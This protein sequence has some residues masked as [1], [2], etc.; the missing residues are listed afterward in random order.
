MID[1]YPSTE[2]RRQCRRRRRRFCCASVRASWSSCQVMDQPEKVCTHSDSRRCRRPT[3]SDFQWLQQFHDVTGIKSMPTTAH[4]S[5][6][7]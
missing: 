1:C 2:P 6:C 4:H 3:D 7:V 5:N